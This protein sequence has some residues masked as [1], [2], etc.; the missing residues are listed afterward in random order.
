MLILQPDHLSGVD[1]VFQCNWLVVKT[2]R[3]LSAHTDSFLLSQVP[4]YESR[5]LEIL[6]ELLL[7]LF[8]LFKS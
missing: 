2:S 8:E 5:K 6:E 4:L 7:E 1:Q 3:D